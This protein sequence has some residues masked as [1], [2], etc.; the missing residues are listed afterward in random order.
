[1]ETVLHDV[2]SPSASFIYVAPQAEERLLATIVNEVTLQLGDLKVLGL[3]RLGLSGAVVV[4]GDKPSYGDTRDF[5]QALHAARSDIQGLVWDSRQT[6]K[7][8]IVLFEDRLPE[9]AFVCLDSTLVSDKSVQ[10]VL[11][12]LLETLGASAI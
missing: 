2:P 1:M 3:K 5:A 9:N 7:Q 10:N 4:D 11:Y 12:D 6:K 8:V